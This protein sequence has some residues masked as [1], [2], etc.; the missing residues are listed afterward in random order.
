M[1]HIEPPEGCC[2]WQWRQ[3]SLKSSWDFLLS[4]YQLSWKSWDCSGDSV[5]LSLWDL[6]S[7]PATPLGWVFVQS[8]IHWWGSYVWSLRD[9]QAQSGSLQ[10]SRKKNKRISFKWHYF[11][12][13]FSPHQGSGFWE[14]LGLDKAGKNGK[15]KWMKF[16]RPRREQKKRAERYKDGPGLVPVS[17]S[18]RLGVRL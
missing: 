3:H 15:P 9:L 2:I 13:S 14:V 7:L 8:P 18:S 10:R 17:K 12:L 6:R 11:S 5:H 1:A 4:G 16:W